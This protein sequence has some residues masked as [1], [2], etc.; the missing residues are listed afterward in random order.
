M[1]APQYGICPEVEGVQIYRTIGDPDLPPGF[2][3]RCRCGWKSGPVASAET[4]ELLR[5]QHENECEWPR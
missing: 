4:A 2:G 5:E 3:V 1:G